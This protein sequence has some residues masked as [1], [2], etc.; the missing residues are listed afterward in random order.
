MPEK[1]QMA[2]AARNREHPKKESMERERRERMSDGPVP[3]S[4]VTDQC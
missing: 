3:R 4:A 2:D 1:V